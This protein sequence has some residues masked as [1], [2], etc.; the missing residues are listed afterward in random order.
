MI[1]NVEQLCKVK[2]ALADLYFFKDIPIKTFFRL[3][4]L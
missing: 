4:L 2:V 1:L 3:Q